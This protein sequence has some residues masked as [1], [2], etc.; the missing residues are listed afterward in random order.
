LVEPASGQVLASAGVWLTSTL[1]GTVAISLCTLAVAFVGL[2]MLTGR[3]DVRRGMRV[4]LGCFILLGAPVI[5]NGLLAGAQAVG[6]TAAEPQDLDITV[7]EPP[8]PAH[9]DPYAGAS[10]R[11]D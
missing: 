5:A 1:L 8:P 9:Y 2:Q 11:R 3:L 6:G 4:V 10:L 7:P